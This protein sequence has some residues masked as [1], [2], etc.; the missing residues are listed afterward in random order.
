MAFVCGYVVKGIF[1]NVGRCW[2]HKRSG[3]WCSLKDSGLYA[4]QKV[5]VRNRSTLCINVIAMWHGCRAQTH[6][7][8]LVCCFLQDD[9]RH[10]C[11]EC[12][13]SYSRAANL[14][15]HKAEV[16]YGEVGRRRHRCRRCGRDFASRG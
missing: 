6:V 1:C 11:D 8:Y 13:R 2:N 9:M 4:T 16:H 12:G 7:S 15:R 10:V 14:D 3:Y 5:G